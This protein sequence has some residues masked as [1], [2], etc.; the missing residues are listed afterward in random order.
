MRLVRIHCSVP[1]CDL[2]ESKDFM[3]NSVKMDLV[4]HRNLLI[5]SDVNQ[6]DLFYQQ[7]LIEVRSRHMDRPILCAHRKLFCQAVHPSFC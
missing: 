7:F 4:G 1:A 5:L 3:A 2:C 6:F